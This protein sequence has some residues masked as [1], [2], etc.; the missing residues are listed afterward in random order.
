[1]ITFEEFKE[2]QERY[3][4]AEQD[5]TPF[6]VTQDD[7]L[8]V[9]GDPNRTERKEHDYIVRF[10]FPKTDQY[11]NEK[12]IRET[13]SYLLCERE[14]KNVFIPTRRHSSVVNAFIRIAQFM[15]QVNEDGTVRTMT[16]DETRMMFE[17]LSDDIADAVI[18]AVAKVLRL[19]EFEAD[20][21]IV[22]SAM[23]VITQMVSDIPEVINES[24][25]FFGSSQGIRQ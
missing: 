25:Y 2:L 17:A 6:L 4:E 14:Y 1:M 12:I 5:D 16:E 23:E 15:N 11:R 9:A 19:S 22:T 8:H 18:D 10:A 3:K 7:E 21:M 20:C 13:D 24:D